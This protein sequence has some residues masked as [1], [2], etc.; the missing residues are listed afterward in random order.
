MNEINE[1][2]S[3][4]VLYKKFRRHFT[5]PTRDLIKYLMDQNIL[6]ATQIAQQMGISRETLYNKYINEPTTT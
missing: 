3:Y 2:D 5:G 4:P 1:V 6:N